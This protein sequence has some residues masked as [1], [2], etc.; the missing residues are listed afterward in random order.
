MTTVLQGVDSDL[1]K[2]LGA[3]GDR[4]D[5][6]L[7]DRAYRL[8]AT[9]HRGQKRLSGE[10]FL[11]HAVAVARILLEH[12]M[13]AVTIAAALLHD[14]VE[15][16][17]VSIEQIREQFGGEIGDIVDGLTK[18]SS[19]SFRSSTEEQVEN[20]RKLLLSVAKDARVIVVKLA[21]RLHNMRTLKHLSPARRKRIALMRPKLR[22]EPRPLQT[23]PRPRGTKKPLRRA[24]SSVVRC[25]S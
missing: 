2:A 8:S 9:A 22:R 11:S 12:H 1:A 14:T 25:T 21:D 4:L 20:Y 18:I 24:R 15:D 7:I 3:Q 6:E 16:S 13:D 10:D 23:R 17:D 5:L 19:L